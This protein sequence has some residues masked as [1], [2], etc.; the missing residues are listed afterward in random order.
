MR[1]TLA[2]VLL[3]DQKTA[4]AN[5]LVTF[6]AL[7]PLCSITD[8]GLQCLSPWQCTSSVPPTMPGFGF[9]PWDTINKQPV[10]PVALGISTPRANKHQREFLSTHS[11]YVGVCSYNNP[12]KLGLTISCHVHRRVAQHFQT[13]RGYWPLEGTFS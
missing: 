2:Y 8:F 10:F 12:Q 1:G 5:F 13:M 3:Y 11:R 9:G 6:N 7:K 4:T